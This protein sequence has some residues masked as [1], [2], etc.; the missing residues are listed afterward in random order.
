MVLEFL[1]PSE[2]AEASSAVARWV[3]RVLL[4]DSRYTYP[5]ILCLVHRSKDFVDGHART[6]IEITGTSSAGLNGKKD[7]FYMKSET[8]RQYAA[9]L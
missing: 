1:A 2:R 3:V 9:C 6:L 5:Y 4:A 8:L 7:L